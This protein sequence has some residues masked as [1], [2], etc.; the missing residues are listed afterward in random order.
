MII[1]LLWKNL[2][3]FPK[4][5]IYRADYYAKAIDLWHKEEINDALFYLGAALHIIQDM[6][7][8]Q[9]ANIRLLDNHHQYE[10]FVKR[11]YKY[12]KSFKVDTGA[13]LIM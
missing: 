9:H 2:S 13:Y 8:P 12:T 4:D 3:L 6:T 1:F 10:T 7:V 11:S 5:H